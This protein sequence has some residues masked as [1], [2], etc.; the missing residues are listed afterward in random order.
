MKK[1]LALFFVFIFSLTVA[2]GT[3]P[4]RVFAQTPA[5]WWRIVTP[6]TAGVD[7]LVAALPKTAEQKL[8]IPILIGIGPENF[9]HNYGITY[10]NGSVHQGEDI[11]APRGA[12]VVTPTQA[13]VTRIDTAGAGGIA[14]Y[15]AN[16]GEETFYYAHLTAVGPTIH[17]GAKLEQGDLIGY[18]GNTG[19]AAG[20]SPHLH[21][22]IFA[23]NTGV[24][25]P[26][27]RLT[28]IFSDDERIAALGKI[29]ERSDNP[30]LA[31]RAIANLYPSFFATL[32]ANHVP[33]AP[34]LAR[35]LGGENANPL[36]TDISA[37][38]VQVAGIEAAATSAGEVADN[39]ITY[40][41]SITPII[42]S[43]DLS[44]GARNDSVKLLQQYLIA[45]HTGIFAQTLATYGATGYFG[46]LTRAALIEFQRAHSISGSGFCG[47]IT[48]AY[49]ASH[50]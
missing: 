22:Q 2:G 9:K 24:V 18:V 3:I 30:D 50:P 35:A 38:D 26:T 5:N 49:I 21:F 19:D 43:Q 15:T 42:I 40:T 44:I 4:A 31:A 48:R 28:E 17:V 8:K 29:I 7:A 10:A 13:V 12:Y 39:L 41:S 20:A 1:T 47:P 27:V 23:L 36:A 25:D 32:P 34:E 14:V 37:A 45:Q 33:L 16:P 11:F 46:T 6:T